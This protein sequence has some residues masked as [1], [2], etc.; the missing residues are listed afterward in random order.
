MRKTQKTAKIDLETP[1]KIKTLQIVY[2]ENHEILKNCSERIT[3]QNVTR[4]V[5]N[6]IKWG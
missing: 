1:Q 5:P 3:A 2:E 4:G 6:A